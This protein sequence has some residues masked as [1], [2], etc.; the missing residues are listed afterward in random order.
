[1]KKKHRYILIAWASLIWGAWLLYLLR[2]EYF[3]S[4]NIASLISELGIF[5][6]FIYLILFSVRGFLLLP[7]TIMIIIG[8][9]V[10]DPATLLILGSL[11]VLISSSILYFLARYLKFWKEAGKQFGKKKIHKI[12]KKIN[13]HAF[14]YV[15]LWS[16]FPIVPTDL[17]CIVAGATKMPYKKFA[18]WVLIGTLPF[19]YAYAILGESLSSYLF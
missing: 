7:S 16:A 2:P 9:L 5:L 10:F 18:A 15:T 4:E 11:W 12:T 19:I 17:I 14:A 3:D 1:M 6:I 8:A 13:K